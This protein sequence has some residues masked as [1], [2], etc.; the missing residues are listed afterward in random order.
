MKITIA[1]RISQLFFLLLFFWLCLVMTLGEQ[2]WE[3]RGWPVNLFLNLDPLTGMGM[4]LS[5]GTLY[6]G[7]L[8]GLVTVVLTLVLGRFFC[9]WLCPFG[10]LHQAIGYL[11]HRKKNPAQRAKHNRPSRWQNFKYLILLVFLGATLAGGLFSHRPTVE[12]SLLTGLLDPIPLMHR[13]VNLFLLPLAD[14]FSPGTRFYAG[15]ASIALVFVAALGMNLWRPRFYC[16]FVCPLGALLGLLS[17]YCLYRI[18]KTWDECAHCMLCESNCEGACAPAG[19]IRVHECVLCMNCLH[20]CFHDRIRYQPWPSASGQQVGPDRS[21]RELVFSLAGGVLLIPG[22]RL[23]GAVGPNWDPHRIRPPGALPEAAFLSRCIQCGQCMRICP[24][25]VIH[26]AGLR[27]GPE[28]V[29]TPVLNFRVGTSGCQFNCIACGQVCPTAAIRPLSLAERQG[30]GAFEKRGPVR[31]GMAFVDQGR[32]LP[33]AMDRPC[34]VCQE[35]CPVSPKAIKTQVHFAE[36]AR[37]PVRAVQAKTLELGGEPLP[38]DRLGTGD[39]FC[40]FGEQRRRILAN[41]AHGLTLQSAWDRPPAASDSVAILI[42]LQ[43]PV[44]D[45]SRC[46][47]CGVCEHECPVQGRPA[48]RVTAENQ[49]REPTHGI[50]LG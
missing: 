4:L 8:W 22:L 43:R 42:R 49:S 28:G 19:T 47:G 16:R 13:S 2:W 12:G 17:R 27:A 3:L 31:I 39:Y 21:R 6:S 15:T 45:P 11:A 5:T 20:G 18:G 50:L 9:G 36:F 23:S 32:C 40:R 41:T 33:W 1:R 46:I 26:P 48:I 10:T 34:I 30:K 24:T 29:W 37:C 38:P 44:V 35:N 7:L 25:N 14:G